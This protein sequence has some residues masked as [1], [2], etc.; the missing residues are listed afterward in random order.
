MPPDPPRGLGDHTTAA[1]KNPAGNTAS[2]SKHDK[3][4]PTCSDLKLHIITLTWKV[5]CHSHSTITYQH[6]NPALGRAICRVHKVRQQ[7]NG[8]DSA[9]F[10]QKLGLVSYRWSVSQ[11]C[12]QARCQGLQD[13]HYNG[14]HSSSSARA[15]SIFSREGLRWEE[16]T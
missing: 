5:S 12:T 3:L 10:A 9:S 1:E 16:R 8:P 7:I 4:T 6:P 2:F 14:G 15:T 11:K 13:E